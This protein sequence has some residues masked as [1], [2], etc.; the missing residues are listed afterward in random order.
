M[1]LNTSFP[2][3]LCH[4]AL[5]ISYL[6][7]KMYVLNIALNTIVFFLQ[8]PRGC[9]AIDVVV[10]IRAKFLEGRLEGEFIVVCDARKEAQFRL[11]ELNDAQVS[12]YY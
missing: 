1:Y 8:I 11:Q 5:L 6:K 2:Q 7:V 3:L 10:A 9:S 12:K 4:S